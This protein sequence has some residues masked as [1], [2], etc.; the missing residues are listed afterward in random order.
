MPVQRPWS[1]SPRFVFRGIVIFGLI[2]LALLV[3]NVVLD[4]FST[5][6]IVEIESDVHKIRRLQNQATDQAAPGTTGSQQSGP[7]PSAS[8]APSRSSQARANIRT[9]IDNFRTSRAKGKISVPSPDSV[10]S[11]LKAVGSPFDPSLFPSYSGSTGQTGSHWS[12]YYSQRAQQLGLMN[13]AKRSSSK[14]TPANYDADVDGDGLADVAV[15]FL[16][17]FMIIPAQ[18]PQPLTLTPGT[19]FMWTPIS[20]PTDYA[21]TREP[22][23]PL[24]SSVG[25]T[26]LPLGDDDNV[27]LSIGHSFPF[28]GTEWNTIF[29]NSDGTVTF[30]SSSSNSETRNLIRMFT[31]PPMI[32]PLLSDLDNTCTA[33]GNGIFFQTT[34]SSTIITWQH[35]PTYN[36]LT[37][38]CGVYTG[39]D[40]SFQIILYPSGQFEWRYGVLSDIACVCAQYK[41]IA[42]TAVTLGPGQ[43]S[44]ETYLDFPL[45]TGT[46][47][48]RL[49]T[50]LQF[51]EPDGFP[52]QSLFSALAFDKFYET[53][54]DIYDHVMSMH[55]GFGTILDTLV[56]GSAANFFRPAI[57][58]TTGLGENLGFFVTSLVD[59]TTELEGEINLRALERMKGMSETEIREGIYAKITNSIWRDKTKEGFSNR[60][61]LGSIGGVNFTGYPW[62]VNFTG[63]TPVSNPAAPF[64]IDLTANGASS[65][66]THE[67][68]GVPSGARMS[69]A[70]SGGS[71][72]QTA[73]HELTHRWNAYQ[74][75][76]YPDNTQWGDHF[77]DLLSRGPNGIGGS[78]PG[79]LNDLRVQTTP[80]TNPWAD[81]DSK[82]TPKRPRGDLMSYSSAHITQ[83]IPNP[84]DQSSFVDALNPSTVYPDTPS[85]DMAVADE[86]CRAQGLDLFVTTPQARPGGLSTRSLAFAGIVPLN[87]SDVRSSANFYVDSPRS[88]YGA[89]G[90]DFDLRQVS[91][92]NALAVQNL[93]FCGRRREYTV[94]DT[95]QISDVRLSAS[96]MAFLGPMRGPSSNQALLGQ[97]FYGKRGPLIG[98]EADDI[99]LAVKAQYPQ[100]YSR[101]NLDNCP[102]V[103]SASCNGGFF[104][105]YDAVCLDVK[106]VAPVLFVAPGYKPS[107]NDFNQYGK[108]LNVLRR[109]L[110]KFELQGHGARGMEGDMCYIPKFSFG[111]PQLIH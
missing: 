23:A 104:G 90:F 28:N 55:V 77:F 72:F 46:T 40:S 110:A 6:K 18:P 9:A 75:L 22:D 3:T 76:R 65:G 83:L 48:V 41:F 25:H 69:L 47:N 80:T 13:S 17:D 85:F 87:D 94:A 35:V 100:L 10:R 62:E 57:Q 19:H 98:D 49:G 103:S 38:T 50:A 64:F 30:G 59:G 16:D 111:I 4:S 29:V 45:L 1:P 12:S 44:P 102:L 27:E 54:D 58:E 106:T 63:Y 15:V 107:Q 109:D 79:T 31:S 33:P 108:L 14:P 67:A 86:L 101:L 74:G 53:H 66:Y 84:S 52:Y 71:M 70:P 82:F 39:L 96:A 93:L 26:E 81:G 91:G 78:H 24:L 97:L 43:Y 42:L 7:K 21:I 95:T 99:D 61:I 32:A 34:S 20:A 89:L 2:C 105:R 88:P 36:A 5:A 11:T 92:L 8:S 68:P 56:D 73:V 51:W 37:T 60:F